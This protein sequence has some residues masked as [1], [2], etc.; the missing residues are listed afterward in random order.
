[1]P[2]DSSGIYTLPPGNPVTPGTIIEADWANVTMPDL[3]TALTGSLSRDGDGGMRSQLGIVDGTVAQPG[4]YF[5]ADTP[6]GIYRTADD[7]WHLVAASQVIFTINSAGVIVAPGKTLTVPVF[8]TPIIA[9]TGNISFV[10]NTFTQVLIAQRDNAVNYL[11]LRGGVA[12]EFVLIQASGTDTDID[13][14]L[15]PKGAGIVYAKSGGTGFFVCASIPTNAGHLTNK[16]YVDALA[17]WQSSFKFVSTAAPT[18]GDGADG[19]IWFQ[20]V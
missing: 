9:N 15:F 12:S 16:N 18:A 11:S 1:M 5:L 19:D 7:T 8:N 3:G 2:R 4:I 20:Y 10:I 6:N 13:I 17:P 14:Q